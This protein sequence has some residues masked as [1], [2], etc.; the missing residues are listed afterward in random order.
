MADI[1]S[2]QSL[3]L[4]AIGGVATLIGKYILDRFTESNKAAIAIAA[5]RKERYHE[6]QAASIAG[7]YEKLTMYVDVVCGLYLYEASNLSKEEE[8]R[9]EKELDEAN[10]AREGFEKYFA[11]NEIYFPVSLASKVETLKRD[12]GRA[13]RTHRQIAGRSP[14]VQSPEND[15]NL[16]INETRTSAINL[17]DELKS[18]FRE[19]LLGN[20]KPA[21]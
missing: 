8:Q 10:Q 6:K 21:D 20:E 1:L 4:G 16:R 5:K 15:K 18:K 9:I 14:N 17:L 2:A 19:L 12:L 11:A 3:I 7:T 13:L